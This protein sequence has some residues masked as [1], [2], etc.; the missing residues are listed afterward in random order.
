MKKIR[1]FLERVLFFLRLTDD[2]GLL[3]ITHIACMVVLYKVA[4]EKEPSVADMGALLITLSLYYGKR[5]NQSRKTL[6]SDGGKQAI[7]DIQ[8][9][10][11]QLQDKLSGVAATVGFRN[12][13]K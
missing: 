5:Y 13:Q 8:T 7:T 9:K 6:I 4:T 11:Q 12:L 10:V 1:S 2:D 3:S